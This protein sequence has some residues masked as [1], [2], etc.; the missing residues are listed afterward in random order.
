VQWIKIGFNR[1]RADQITWLQVLQSSGQFVV[2]AQPINQEI[3][4]G[5]TTQEDAAAAADAFIASLNE[6]S[7]SV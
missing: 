6:V 1:Y 5:F 4:G 3:A 2:M 7:G